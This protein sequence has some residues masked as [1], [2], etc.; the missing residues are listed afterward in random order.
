MKKIMITLVMIVAML[1]AGCSQMVKEAVDN[2]LK[3]SHLENYVTTVCYDLIDKTDCPKSWYQYDINIM[4]FVPLSSRF[5]F[6]V[7][8]ENEVLMLQG[9]VCYSYDVLKSY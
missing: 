3:Y 1:S 4:P 8:P 7:L 2:H 5:C 9:K 6:S